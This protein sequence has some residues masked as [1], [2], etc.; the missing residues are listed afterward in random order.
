M[1][2]FICHTEKLKLSFISSGEIF[3]VLERVM[4]SDVMIDNVSDCGG[5]M[6]TFL[7]RQDQKQGDLLGDFCNILLR[8][9]KSLNQGNGSMEEW[10]GRKGSKLCWMSI[11]Q[12][13]II[14]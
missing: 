4:Q 3:E 14:D 6:D 5:R 8:K 1:E 10:R 9:C 11:G 7:M 2:G 13:L 12:E